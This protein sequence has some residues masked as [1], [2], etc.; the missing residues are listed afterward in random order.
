ML[1][2]DV[3]FK[4]DRLVVERRSIE[5]ADEARVA[6][7]Q[8]LLLFLT[9]QIGERVD[10]HTEDQVQH[11]NDDHE[12]EQKVVDDSGYKQ[13]FLQRESSVTNLSYCQSSSSMYL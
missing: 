11:N 8:L 1:A 6:K 2:L 9:P 3:F 5:T 7:N 10:D 12:E 13:R 4:A